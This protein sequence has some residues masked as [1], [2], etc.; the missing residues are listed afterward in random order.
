ME[1][2]APARSGEDPPAPGCNHVNICLQAFVTDQTSVRPRELRLSMI[3]SHGTPA[4]F[5]KAGPARL[6]I[7]GMRLEG[8]SATTVHRLIKPATSGRSRPAKLRIGSVK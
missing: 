1:V 3:S 5:A 4:Q 2:N 6:E 8:S 7:G